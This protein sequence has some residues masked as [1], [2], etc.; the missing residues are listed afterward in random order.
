MTDKKVTPVQI[1]RSW[2]REHPTAT[3]CI[4]VQYLVPKGRG[5]RRGMAI[6]RDHYLVDGGKAAKL[7]TRR[8]V[9]PDGKIR[10]RSFNGYCYHCG[11]IFLET[12]LRSCYIPNP[13]AGQTVK[14]DMLERVYAPLGNAAL[15]PECAHDLSAVGFDDGKMVF[16]EQGQMMAWLGGGDGDCK[17]RPLTVILLEA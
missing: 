15:C 9:S 5:G 13:W 3:G 11:S 6:R 1:A 2:A 4:A 17:R 16:A 7:A 12:V 14:D 10:L 8:T